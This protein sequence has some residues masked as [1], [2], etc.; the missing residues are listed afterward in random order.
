M[1][2]LL[3]SI[4]YVFTLQSS[5]AQNPSPGVEQS[6]PILL[7]GGIAHVGN[8]QVIKNAVLAFDKGIIT[9][10]KGSGVDIDEKSY[11][12]SDRTVK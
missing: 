7:K 10:I 11:D 2:K 4:L 5:I 6:T 1:K 8:G 12:V 9:L 3:A